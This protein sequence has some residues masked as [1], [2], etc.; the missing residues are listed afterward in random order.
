MSS[1]DVVR[2]VPQTPTC[3][4]VHFLREFS[5]MNTTHLLQSVCRSENA[6][7]PIV[8]R[9]RRLTSLRQ[10]E[11]SRSGRRPYRSNLFVATM[12]Q[13]CLMPMIE[14]FPVRRDRR[15]GSLASSESSGEGLV[16]AMPRCQ[17]F[18][19]GARGERSRDETSTCVMP[20]LMSPQRQRRRTRKVCN[21]TKREN[22][23]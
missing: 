6:T 15:M 21:R 11:A 22:S 1:I 20:P 3:F 19:V 12:A 4:L 7:R 5:V 16:N 14:Q 9:P 18:S 17:L 13:Q 2:R 23:G 10:Q 8:F